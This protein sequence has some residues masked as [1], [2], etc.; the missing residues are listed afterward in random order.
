MCVK[1]L[2]Y[3]RHKLGEGNFITVLEY[4]M[5]V[6]VIILVPRGLKFGMLLL[7]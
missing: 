6:F 5:Y 1:N 4:K 2:V 3:E 7:L